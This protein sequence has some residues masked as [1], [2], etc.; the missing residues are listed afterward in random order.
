MVLLIHTYC[1]PVYV[2]YI[3]VCRNIDLCTYIVFWPA[4][5]SGELTFSPA[6]SEGFDDPD[7]RYR[8]NSNMLGQSTQWTGVSSERAR[9]GPAHLDISSETCTQSCWRTTHSHARTHARTHARAHACTQSSG[10]C[11]CV[12]C[13]LQP[14]VGIR[15]SKGKTRWPGTAKSG[16][17]L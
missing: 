15:P 13:V 10:C 7:W 17:I 2:Q 8:T 5:R 3:N 14:L 16:N 6:L 11:V 12:L 4:L 9:W 1:M